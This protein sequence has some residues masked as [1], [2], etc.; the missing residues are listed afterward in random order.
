MFFIFRLQDISGIDQSE[1]NSVSLPSPRASTPRL[2]ESVNNSEPCETAIDA[3]PVSSPRLNERVN[4][5]EPR[6]IVR[7]AV[8]GRVNHAR[9]GRPRGSRGSRYQGRNR[10]NTYALRQLPRVNYKE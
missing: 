3:L 5:P 9:A 1:N 4:N 8:R 7:G 2:D 6:D 10:T